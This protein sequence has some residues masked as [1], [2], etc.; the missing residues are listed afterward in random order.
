M[1]GALLL[2]LGYVPKIRLLSP[3]SPE[4]TF[5]TKISQR[6]GSRYIYIYYFY[7]YIYIYHHIPCGFPSASAW[8][9]Y[10]P[11]I[12]ARSPSSEEAFVIAKG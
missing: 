2:F 9:S 1:E 5:V 12:V 4:K 3:F 7:I 8:R 11:R 10:A 6:C